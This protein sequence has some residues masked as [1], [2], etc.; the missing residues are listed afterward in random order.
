MPFLSLQC[1]TYF[2]RYTDFEKVARER[3]REK[4]KKRDREKRT[5]WE[6]DGDKK[7]KSTRYGV[8]TTNTLSLPACLHPHRK[9]LQRA[10]SLS[11][12]TQIKETMCRRALGNSKGCANR[13]P[14]NTKKMSTAAS[15]FPKKG[16]CKN[17]PSNLRARGRFERSWTCS[18][19]HALREAFRV[20]WGGW[21]VIG[22]RGGGGGSRADLKLFMDED[23]LQNHGCFD[24]P[25]ESH[26]CIMEI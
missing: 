12:R 14:V 13:K 1:E 10:H 22:E 18:R 6:H 17:M 4:E 5:Q 11:F 23:G 19:A 21:G 3:E 9:V 8:K 24:C 20:A 26:N 16:N 25:S 7:K 2:T 15:P